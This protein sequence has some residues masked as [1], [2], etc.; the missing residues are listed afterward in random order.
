MSEQQT[1]QQAAAPAPAAPEEQ[2][3]EN[4]PTNEKEEI[5]ENGTGDA[6]EN[7]EAVAAPKEMRAVILTGFGGL[8][9]V[10]TQ[11]KNEPSVSE[12]EVL[13]RVKA[14]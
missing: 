4:P 10:K 1:E 9:T 13:I 2:K 5:K 3:T 8:K 7:T 11:K 12:G 14:W 6:G